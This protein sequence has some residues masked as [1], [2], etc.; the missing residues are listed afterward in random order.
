MGYTAHV[1][2]FARDNLPPPERMPELLFE[3]PEFRYPARLNCA[4]ELLDHVVA[5][6]HGDRPVIH[7]LIDARKY[8]CTYRQLLVRANQI[9]HAL[10]DDFGLVPGNRVL[11][12]APNNP[13]MAACWLGVIKAGCIAVATMPLLRAKELKQIID[14]AQITAALS[15]FRLAE[16][17]EIARAQCATLKQV[18]YFNGG[19]AGS[20]EA[21]IDGK[22]AGFANVDTAADD[23]ALIAFTSGTTGQPKGCI[24]FHRDVMAMCDAFPRSCLEPEPDDVF[25][26]TP[27]LAFTFGLGGMLCFPMRAGASTVLIERLTPESLLQAIQD[28]RATVCFTA[29]TFYR[30]MAQIAGRYDLS[31]LRKCVSAGEALPDATRQL[32]KRATGLELFD[33]LGST[34]MIHIFVSHAADRVRPGATGYAIPGYRATVLDDDGNPCPPGV[35]GRLAVKGPTGCKYL[36]D[37]RQQ[38]YVQHGWN[39]TGDAYLMD[40]D[41]YFFYQ[42]RTDDMI[43]SAGYN[44]AG[45]E[46]EAVLLEHEAVAECGV[47]GAPDEERGM[48]VKAYVVLKPGFNSD[49]AMATRLQD[50]IKATIAP[51]KYPRSIEFRDALPRTETGKLQRFKL[52]QE[53]ASDAG[54][55]P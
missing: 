11:L 28:F 53:A 15:D 21:L 4:V 32:F 43:I 17:M 25:C 37:E 12:R 7:T 31:S 29:P 55:R 30:Q 5:T 45:P 24:H 13:M 14:K 18:R 48:I 39:V 8:A 38:V 19:G 22:P 27:P 1:D 41:G 33:G 3:R 42:A 47:V 35:V 9:A 46:V 16:E 26:G 52:R 20:L 54:L 6:G 44:I 36:A 34:E 2:T 23:V 50:Y 51:Y 49:P 40:E 10:V